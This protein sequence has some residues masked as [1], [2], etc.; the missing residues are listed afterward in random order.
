M[1][2][3]D[4]SYGEGGGQ[5]LRTALALSIVA[6][7]AFRL[8]QIRA[9]REKPGLRPQH[10][11]AVRAAAEV[12]GAA[13]RGDAVGSSELEFSPKSCKVGEFRFEL[14]TA[15]AATLVLQTVLPPLAL[16]GAPSRVFLRGGTH[17]PWCP[18]FDYLADVFLPAVA[19]AGV[20]ARATLGRAGFYPKGGG[21]IEAAVEPVAP[22]SLPVPVPVPGSVPEG[23]ERVGLAPIVLDR[24][25][26]LRRIEVRALISNLPSHIAQRE[27]DRA[28][29]VLGKVAA[30]AGAEL[31]VGV[32]RL[33][34]EGPGTMVF[35]LASFED[36]TAA[37]F[38]ALGELGK[39]AER[40]AE[41]AASALCAF[42]ASGASV[43]PHLCDQLIPYMALAAGRSR[44]LTSELTEH[45]RT[46]IWLVER[47]LPVR[48]AV[49]EAAPG[50]PAE[51]EVD[52]AAKQ[53]GG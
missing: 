43:D 20:R 32:R 52:G 4:G 21:E 25:G 53:L 28:G 35:A 13:V 29:R 46:C 2:E 27:C 9:G 48:F 6:R 37:G 14:S 5:I 44:I 24:R 10:L 41:E 49:R 38:D 15:G 31:D 34:A 19:R 18:P 30:E 7:K 50:A 12:S 17:V 16:A 51:V 42:L 8:K 45:A 40:V 11:L 3:I 23:A 1:L 39:P 26:P 22:P 36:G 33:P 47:F